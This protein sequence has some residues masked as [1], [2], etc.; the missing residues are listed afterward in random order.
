MKNPKLLIIS[1]LCI[2]ILLAVWYAGFIRFIDAIPKTRQTNTSPTDAIIVL[3]GG[4]ERKGRLHLN[5]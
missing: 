2:G 3:T 1:T 5:K 4:S